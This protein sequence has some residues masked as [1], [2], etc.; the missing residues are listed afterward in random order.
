V[1]YFINSCSVLAGDHQGYVVD[2]AR[3]PYPG[4]S[5]LQSVE[6]WAKV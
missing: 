2:I 5:G 3:G 1:A 6:Q 4:V